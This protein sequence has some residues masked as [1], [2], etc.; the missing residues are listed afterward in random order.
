M[1][2]APD[3]TRESWW[4]SRP[5][6]RSF[7]TLQVGAQ[8]SLGGSRTRQSAGNQPNGP[9][10]GERGDTISV[11]LLLKLHKIQHPSPRVLVELFPHD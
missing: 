8:R 9:R 6:S 3:I 7:E 10:S 11:E 1:E 5:T 2:F 4:T